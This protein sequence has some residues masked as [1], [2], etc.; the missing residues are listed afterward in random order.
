MRTSVTQNEQPVADIDNVDQPIPDDGVAP[1]NDL[2]L[3]IGIGGIRVEEL[4][5]RGRR[6]CAEGWILGGDY[7]IGV[8]LK[9]PAW[10]GLV[11][12]EISIACTPPECQSI[13]ARF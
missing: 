4:V 13:N 8:G 1:H 5:H 12:S 7:G 9:T 11:A 2:G 10:V 3:E 6:T